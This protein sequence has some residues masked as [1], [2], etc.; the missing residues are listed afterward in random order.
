M[1]APGVNI[2]SALPEETYG[3][4]D[5]TSMAAPHVAGLAALVWS[6][7]PGLNNSQVRQIIEDTCV[8][9]DPLNPGYA[10]LLGRGRINAFRAVDWPSSS[11]PTRHRSRHWPSGTGRLVSYGQLPSQ[12][13]SG[14]SAMA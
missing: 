9:A 1:C 8:S 13:I 10:G 12:A 2:Y 11:R 5:G 7:S 6:V 14:Q 4:L 3:F